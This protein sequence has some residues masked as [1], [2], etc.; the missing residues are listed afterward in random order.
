MKRIL[1]P[2]LT[3]A[4]LAL[5]ATMAHAAGSGLV[6]QPGSKLWLTGTSTMHAYTSNATRLDVAFQMAAGTLAAG[7][8]IE[9][10][11]RDHAVSNLDVAIPV[12]GLRSHKEGLDKNLYKAL[13]AE[14]HPEIRF[15]MTGYEV[16]DADSG[17]L[18]IA[19]RGKL[20]VAGVEK[21]IRVAVVAKREAGAM[22]LTGEVPLM[23]TQFGIKPPT[24]MMGAIKTGDGV[25]IHFDLRIGAGNDRAAAA[26]AESHP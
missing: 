2:A 13:L 14:K 15:T 26:P 23:M 25:V 11:I 3:L 17:A 20:T 24:M 22:R 4:T 1:R 6:L 18:A 21:E 10:L 16:T 12:T 9:K 8:S 5:A 19:A 7:E